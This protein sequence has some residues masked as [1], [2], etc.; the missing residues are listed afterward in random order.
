MKNDEIYLSIRKFHYL[1]ENLP[2]FSTLIKYQ[3]IG[4]EHLA[5]NS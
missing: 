5:V 1:I 2:D 4:K 3:D